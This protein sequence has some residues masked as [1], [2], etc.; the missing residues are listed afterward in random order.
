[1]KKI[2][3]YNL[4]IIFSIICYVSCTQETYKEK[5]LRDELITMAKTDQYIRD[6]AS[7]NYPFDKIIDDNFK[8]RWDSIALSHKKRIKEILDTYGWPGYNLV[9]EEASNATWIIVQHLNQEI[10]LQEYALSHLEKAIK[11]NNANPKTLA[12]LTDKVRVLNDQP[13][14][15]GTQINWMTETGYPSPFEIE[16][17]EDVDNRRLRLG[18]D[19]LSHYLKKFTN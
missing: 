16:N 6:Y 1:M 12:F 18:L 5:K 2:Y 4:S 3:V 11:N 15:Y 8:K 17:K 19:S 13:Q 14:L 7:K 10:D 9:G